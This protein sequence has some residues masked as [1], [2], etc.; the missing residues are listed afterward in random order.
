VAVIDRRIGI[1]FIIFVAA[2]GIALARATYLGSV[3]AGSLERAATTQQVSNVVVPAPRGAI[4]DRDGAELA[5]SESA[6]DIVADPYLIKNAVSASAQL[7]SLLGVPQLTVLKRLTRPHT[8]FVY[9]AHLLPTAQANAISALRIAGITLVPKT[10]RVYPRGDEAAQLVG[11]VHLDGVGAGGIEYRYDRALEGK[12]GLRRV[13][14]D[15]IGQPISIDDLHPTV[16]GKTVALTIDS[17]LQ[18][19]VERV[20]AEV[21]A[22]YSPQSA[23]A[24]A[25]DPSTGAI[26]ALANWPASANDGS[27]AG[28][29]DQ[30]I[31]LS[32]EP[33]STFKAITVAGALQ[34]RVVMPNTPFDIPPVLQ[35]ADRQIHDAED[36][37]YETLTVAQILKYSSNIGADLIGQKLGAKQFDYWVHR[38]GFGRPTGVDLPG[39]Q[40][41]IVLHW[42]QYS[43]SSM[44]NLPFGQG[45]SVTPMQ[46][47]AAYSAIA[48]GGIL[49]A[50]HSVQAVGGKPTPLS[51]GH[52]VI[53]PKTAL[54]LRDML[55]GVLAD[56]GT[57]SGA[58]IP[59]YDM[60]GKTG[61][62]N[63]AVGGHYSDS[64]YVAS[65]IGMVPTVHPRLVVAVVVNQPHG[66][67]FGGS[68]AAPAFQQIVGWAVPYLG[69]PPR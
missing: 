64:A 62:A 59:G 33:G 29:E 41:G 44:A 48:N 35:F 2:L 10:R 22:E 31:G 36:H 61:T 7:S 25:V 69:I 3:R 39:E 32:Y 12:N 55:R 52:R 17:G 49:R 43:G 8:G 1:L 45:E 4:T 11:S 37:G 57:A 54:E 68:V 30:A 58:A 18:Q 40:S 42:W 28:L 53:T 15:A 21:G 9:L 26:L 20:L 46:M 63:I 56:G 14:N 38:F 23:T 34:D 65:F 27:S 24:I 16:P 6:D 5:I 19:E 47:V 60:A 66:S 50:P 13:V 51:A 67:I